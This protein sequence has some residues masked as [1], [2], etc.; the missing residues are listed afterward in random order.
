MSSS[1]TVPGLH[2]LPQ[3]VYM[4]SSNM[5]TC[6]PPTCLHVYMTSSNMPTCPPPACLHVLLLRQVLL[7][8][9]ARVLVVFGRSVLVLL[10]LRHQ[11]VHVRLRLRELH[12]VHAFTG[13]PM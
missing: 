13:I 9:V 5:S 1:V 8:H 10:I 11:V 3:N 12:L 6:P 4:S 7:Q 2:V